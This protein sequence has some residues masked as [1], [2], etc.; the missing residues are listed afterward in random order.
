MERSA[1]N[2]IETIGIKT[3]HLTTQVVCE[4]SII[5]LR[6]NYLLVL[7]QYLSGVF[8]QRADELEVCQGHL[9][10]LLLHRLH[11]LVEVSIGTTPT[12][13]QEICIGITDHL[14]LRDVV[15]DLID[16]RLTGANHLLVVL[17]IRRDGAGVIVLLQTTQ[18]VCEALQ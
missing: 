13:D 8:R 9:L 17:R 14:Q 7:A 3:L 4:L 12:Y 11:R 18:T 1:L 2:L 5:L 16:L 15:S 10:A 6:N